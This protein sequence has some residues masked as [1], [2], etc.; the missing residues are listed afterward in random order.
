M[1]KLGSKREEILATSR[2][3]TVFAGIVAVSVPV[4]MLTKRFYVAS[5][6]GPGLPGYILIFILFMC[7]VF[8]AMGHLVRYLTLAVSRDHSGFYSKKRLYGYIAAIIVANMFRV[9]PV[10]AGYF[11]YTRT[12]S[13]GWCIALAVAALILIAASWPREAELTRLFPDSWL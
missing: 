8:L 3:I 12:D 7:L 11:L 13:V 9:L 10:F 1:E 4:Y 5:P 2:L 6:P